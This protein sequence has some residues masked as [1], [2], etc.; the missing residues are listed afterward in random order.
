MITKLFYILCFALFEI[1]DDCKNVDVSQT[2]RL[3]HLLKFKYEFVSNAMMFHEKQ[4]VITHSRVKNIVFN[5]HCREFN[6]IDIQTIN[7]WT[8]FKYLIT[9]T[10]KQI[11]KMLIFFEIYFRFFDLKKT[12]ISN[13]KIDVFDHSINELR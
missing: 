8:N 1:F 6:T 5:I 3:Q 11:Q 9:F 4:N 10:Q 2:C 12:L 7:D 13:K